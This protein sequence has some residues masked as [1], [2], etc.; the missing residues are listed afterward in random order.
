[1]R[2]ID[3]PVGYVVGGDEDVAGAAARTDYAALSGS[4]PALFVS[5]RQG[6]HPTVS[7]DPMILPQVAELA[8]RRLRRAHLA[9]ALQQLSAGDW[10]LTGKNLE[11][12][13]K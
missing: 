8:L 2:A 10:T 6:E 4:V 3:L 5:R 1:M 7:T 11:Q 12:L 13:Q 9:R